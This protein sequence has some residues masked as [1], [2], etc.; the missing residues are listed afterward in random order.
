[1]ELLKPFNQIGKDDAAIA[2]GKGAS[3]GEMTQAGIPVPPGFV[4]L[5]DA[6]ERF[7]IETNLTIEIDSI[8]SKV[9]H[10][11]MHTVEHASETIQGLIL[12]VEMPADLKEEIEK[13]FK[14]LNTEF[15]A[16][17]SSATAED[18][19]E[20]AWAGQLDTFLNTTEET[21]LEN[22][23]ECWASLFT[24]RAIFYRFEKGMNL[25]KISVAVVVQKMVNSDTAGIAFSVHPVTED[26][27]QMIIEAG[28]GLGEAVVSGQVT[29]DSY[30][31]TKEPRTI[32]EKNISEQAQ[33]LYRKAGGGNEWKEISKEKGSSQVLTDQQILSLAEILITIENH[34]GFPVDTEWAMENG[35]L[36]IVQSRPIT[37]LS[38]NVPVK[39][40]IVRTFLKEVKNDKLTLIEADFIPAF[41]VI[42]WLNYYDQDD[43]LKDIYP[44]FYYKNGA[45]SKVY[46]NLTKYHA[47]AKMMLGRY[48]DGK[49]DLNEWTQ[50]F[51]AIERRINKSYLAYFNDPKTDEKSLL[52][53]LA[54][55][56]ELLREMV[57][58]TLFLD[59]FDRSNVEDVLQERDL[60]MQ[61]QNIWETSELQDFS[62]FDLKNKE[63][64]LDAIAN[65]EQSLLQ[66]VFANYTSVPS[67]HEVEKIVNAYNIEELS[68]EVSNAKE[69]IQKNT[70]LKQEARLKLSPKEQVILAFID[71]ASALRDQ[72]KA[73]MNKCDVLLFNLTSDL[74]KVWDIDSTLVPDSFVLDTLKGK[75][76][77]LSLVESI[78][79]RKKKMA[80]IYYGKDRY[81]E[82]DSFQD[83]DLIELDTHYLN[84]NK[85][86]DQ[87]LIKGESAC[88]GVVRG[89]VKVITTQ[90]EFGKLKEGEILVTGMTRPEFVPLMKLAS[91]I[92]TDEGGITS[93]A[94]IVSRELNKP[95]VIG[96]KIATHI[97]KD[98]DEVEVDANNGV[99][100]ILKS[101]STWLSHKD[102]IL[103]F[104]GKGLRTLLTEI[105][106]A[107]YVPLESVI[108]YQDETYKQYYSRKHI[109][110]MS[111]IGKVFFADP[112]A[113]QDTISAL[114]KEFE[115]TSVFFEKFKSDAPISETDIQTLFAV[116][117]RMNKLYGKFDFAYTDAAYE[118]LSDNPVVKQNLDLVEAHKNQLREEYNKILFETGSL[119]TLL[120]DKLSAQFGVPVDDLQWYLSTDL[121]SL[122]STGP[123]SK[124]KLDGRKRGIIF[125]KV[126]EEGDLEFMEGEEA[127]RRI[128]QFG[129]EVIIATDTLK[130]VTAHSTGKV[131][132]GEVFALD[133]NY[134]DFEEL[135]KQMSLMK[136]GQILV[137]PTTAPEHMDAIRKSAA[138]VVD[139]GGLLSHTAIVSR[140]LNIPSIVGTQFASKVLKNGDTVEVD[141][142]A[143]IIR[144]LSQ[145]KDT[146]LIKC[147]SRDHSLFYSYVWRTSNTE[148]GSRWIGINIEDVLFVR[149]QGQE[150]MDV[151]YAETEFSR[152]DNAIANKIL[153]DKEW[154]PNLAAYFKNEWQQ[155]MQFIEKK[156]VL[157]RDELSQFYDHWVNWWEPMAFMM[158]IAEIEEIPQEIKDEAY[159]LRADTQEYSDSG[160]QMF[161]AYMNQNHP[162][163]S[164]Y[165]SVIT[166][167]EVF[168]D[169]FPAES[170]LE[171]RLQGWFMT[172]TH[173]GL[174]SELPKTLKEKR[175]VFET[176]A[177]AGN[178][179]ELVGQSAYK[180]I[181]RGKVRVLTSRDQISEVLEGE[182]LVAAMT[183]PDFFPALEKASAFV[184]DE[185]GITCHAAIVA[186]EMKKPCIIGT[187]F[188]TQILSDGMEVEVDADNGIV[189][190]LTS[191]VRQLSKEDIVISDW[192]FE[193]QQ[194]GEQPVFLCDL[195]SRALVG[196]IQEMT[197]KEEF[198]DYLFTDSDKLNHNPCQRD[199][200]LN[201]VREDMLDRSKRKEFL[202]GSIEVP[203]SFNAV[204][205][206]ITVKLNESISNKELARL[207]RDMDR[208]FLKVIPWFYYPWYVS[209][210]NMLTDFVKVGLEKHRAEIEKICDVDEALLAIVFP[211]KKTN[212]QLEQ[213]EML[214]LVTIAEKNP[215]FATDPVFKERAT[216]YLKKYDYLTTFILSPILPMSYEQL[217]ERV[218]QNVKESF[219]D[220][221]TLQKEA[222]LK[223]QERA[224]QI[225]KILKDDAEIQP[226]IE[227]SRELGYVLTAGVEEAYMASARYLPFIQFVAKRIGVVFEDTKYLLSNEIATALEEDKLIPTAVIDERR[228]GFVLMM[229]DGVQY[230]TFGKKAHELSTWIDD[231]LNKVDHTITEFT[232]QRACKGFARGIV[233][234][235][236]TPSQAHLLQEGEI[237]VCPMTNPD[238]V[239]AMRRSAAIITD[240]GGLLSH[241]AIMSREFGKPC[242]IGTKIATQLLRD[243]DVVEVDA[244]AGIVRIL[245]NSKS[246][247]A[248]N[249]QKL[250][251]WQGEFSYFLSTYFMA[252][253]NQHEVVCLHDGKLWQSYLPL[254]QKEKTLAEGVQIYST[255]ERYTELTN[256]LL[257]GFEELVEQFTTVLK[258]ARLAKEDVADLFNKAL[259]HYNYYSQ[260][261]FFYTD[262]AYEQQEK[263][264]A[265]Q[266]HFKSF[267]SLKLKGRE[268][269]NEIALAPGCFL[270]Q[271]LEKIGNQYGL[272]LQTLKKYSLEE[273]L[274]LM[275]GKTVSEDLLISRDI[276]FMQGK[277]DHTAIS[278]GVTA[279]NKIQ[280]FLDVIESTN[281]LRGQIA[282]KGMY[283]GS[284]RIFRF[285][286]GD[287]HSI[288]SEIEK[289]IPGEILVA[290]TTA[291]EIILACKK[292][293]AI[294]TNQG[295]MMSH[296]AIVARELNIPCIVGTGYATE[297][298]KTGDTI[299]V[300]ANKG[301]VTILESTN[302]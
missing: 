18:G 102:Y 170:I 72:R 298:I 241:A 234:I 157:T 109:A 281:I 223:N 181:V 222:T 123:L 296:A 256:G 225:L 154:F 74:Y 130:G 77:V 113:T 255:A 286:I 5:A 24:P 199:I 219:K 229:K 107:G 258:M 149:L 271:L 203:M 278:I 126:A 288:H 177:S 167:E 159:A 23:R 300:D 82:D 270:D 152:Y 205:D 160:D 183:T 68:K 47:V 208:D 64:I 20:A 60:H 104:E 195:F 245:E 101:D 34:Y 274:L 185:G 90:S 138:M 267:D 33:G 153:T 243:G 262:R 116:F 62:S 237:L 147:F 30:I 166:P 48:L 144:I 51:V 137:A 221:Y 230:T 169:I 50:R 251:Q 66:Y 206:E 297:L 272:S 252:I 61:L 54:E 250:F 83:N 235:A 114:E 148:K 210:E 41:I 213:D 226:W 6:F 105:V 108:S 97:L 202:R 240:E 87:N 236:T 182:I 128:E 53:R 135:K 196:M 162:E 287:I 151:W 70:L 175:F 133:T 17:R 88:R 16:V 292:A 119:F 189:R 27:N 121:L 9:D 282:N 188:A 184:T 214:G 260:T 42:D 124:E 228:E 44:F 212:F 158:Q 78:K 155:I 217:V 65:K 248:S 96:T 67:V 75:E 238:Y 209:K 140:E 190:I 215:D 98:G 284:A 289:M 21:L 118:F 56:D 10:R 145:S 81:V 95:C 301:T 14:E 7:I 269:L 86:E 276:Y 299:E 224:E 35:E 232:G 150:V 164:K 91:A 29:P 165:F 76:H 187:K 264:P 112:N 204:A 293:G 43:S 194:R 254:D 174:I 211:I 80:L 180:G 84:Q 207:W 139:V 231:E 294:V 129:T 259:A 173:F 28:F 110:E 295:G 134:G 172:N 49:L 71:W 79:G 52:S 46:L 253:Y 216:E 99:I 73:L 103:T 227:D 127:V 37:T 261:E 131:I 302:V 125:H 12:N 38:N 268:Y 132:Q 15:V 1:M 36:Y 94:A 92:V 273:I 161:H 59:M 244:N 111:E 265:V 39:D 57:S 19:V 141:A 186:R 257:K 277:K 156:E 69:K 143:G 171:D 247:K 279:S 192:E 291:P 193:A 239:P 163:L 2:G 58:L 266:I 201:K 179:N 8:L 32:I 242:I 63:D 55:A 178:M 26:H 117:V 146:V 136:E 220:N 176:A 115:S 3:L 168:A 283:K 218:T 100:R 263:Y 13:S 22:V 197:G 285:S 40:S 85:L 31:V 25:Q 249:Y 275:D 191:A 120:L 93:H 122:Y 4:I 11:E 45:S 246:L 89:I 290:D 106:G 200:V 198:Y 142:D 280:A 233:R